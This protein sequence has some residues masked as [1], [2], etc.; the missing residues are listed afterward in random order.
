[1]VLSSCPL[2]NCDFYFFSMIVHNNQ[3]DER[4][5]IIPSSLLLFPSAVL[6]RTLALE[7]LH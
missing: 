4:F 5:D 3:T 7:T 1:M 6:A 2:K